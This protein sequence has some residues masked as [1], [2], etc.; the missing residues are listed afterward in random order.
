MN[1]YLIFIAFVMWASMLIIGMKKKK[2]W[3]RFS[4]NIM[5]LNPRTLLA[6]SLVLIALDTLTAFLNY[7]IVPGTFAR[8]EQNELIRW[9]F[10]T[11]NVG[12]YLIAEANTI[13][14]VVGLF[15]ASIWVRWMWFR[16]ALLLCPAMFAF[17]ASSNVISIAVL[18]DSAIFPMLMIV[19]TLVIATVLFHPRCLRW[20]QK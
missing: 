7:T 3:K 15:A 9:A 10:I 4:R 13:I 2:H 11:K 19:S 12:G 18:P 8:F 5:R 16:F 1:W 20:L 14:F 17:A 6:I